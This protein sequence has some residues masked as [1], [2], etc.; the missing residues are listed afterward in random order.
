MIPKYLKNIPNTILEIVSSKADMLNPFVPVNVLNV[1]GSP[2]ISLYNNTEIASLETYKIVRGG[3]DVLISDTFDQFEYEEDN[4][5]YRKSIATGTIPTCEILYYKI[6]SGSGILTQTY[7]TQPFIINNTQFALEFAHRASNTFGYYGGKEILSRIYYDTLAFSRFQVKDDPQN[8]SHQ[9][10]KA[11][12]VTFVS[13]SYLH[14]WIEIK[15]YLPY[16]AI[17]KLHQAQFMDTLYFVI[18]KDSIYDNI[19]L[20][21]MTIEF[22]E[23]D[24]IREVTIRILPA[25]NIHHYQY[26]EILTGIPPLE[27][28]LV[29]IS[30]TNGILGTNITGG[31]GNWNIIWLKNG[32]QV[33]TGTSYNSQD[34]PGDYEVIV[35]D[36]QT[37]ISATDTHSVA[38]L[39][40]NFNVSHEV[41]AIADS[42]NKLITLNAFGTEPFTY[43][44]EY[45]EDN[46]SFEELASTTNVNECENTGYYKYTVTDDNG[47]SKSL[48]IQIIIATHSVTITRNS[49]TLTASVTGCTTP[50]YQWYLN[51]G[52][53]YNAILGATNQDLDITENG[54]YEVV[55]TCSGN[56]KDAI[57]LVLDIGTNAF[58]VVISKVWSDSGTQKAFAEVINAPDGNINI[59]WYQRKSTGW[60]QVGS[61]DTVEITDIGFLKVLATDENN[62]T[63]IDEMPQVTDP[64]RQ[65]LYNKFIISASL[66]NQ[67]TITGFTVPNPASLTENQI[68]ADWFAT[69]GGVKLKFKNVAASSLNR[70][71]YGI[72]YANNKIYISNAIKIY[73]NEVIEF[74]NK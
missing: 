48:T 50:T 32:V 63:V 53:G 27:S 33:G 70:D 71:E 38:N 12:G 54:L 2:Y 29:T 22:G 26:N 58:M 61:G 49:N 65:T 44:W 42:N 56:A 31:S 10:T 43:L 28:H 52:S 20:E 55:A 14:E 1:A 68:N 8:V 37:G 36:T 17:R 46:T 62:N 59:E 19:G 18:L 69:R 41:T 64:D 39:C 74:S 6:T 45:S 13:E 60:I 9:I 21:K 25:T 73:Q 24:K 7:Y 72:D 57:Y 67:F 51:T 30:T 34:L 35:Q 3:D 40:E 5:T 66:E 16:Y 23:G 47:C 15:C 11:N 4:I